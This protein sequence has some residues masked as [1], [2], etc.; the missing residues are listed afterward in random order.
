MTQSDLED[1]I[2]RAIGAHGAWKLKLKT[3]VTTG[4]SD[5]TPQ[6]VRKDDQC[7]FGRWLHGQGIDAQT[8][9]GMPYKVVRRL[10]A[11]FHD[12]AGRVLQYGLDGKRVEA[13][14]LLEGEFAQRSETLVLALT[15]WRGEVQSAA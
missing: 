14:Q 5:A 1:A 4:R 3:A 12:C 13:N 11:E 6:T 8:R 10:H 2:R 7:E 15:K 9:A